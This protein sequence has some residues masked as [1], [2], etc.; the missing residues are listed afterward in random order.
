MHSIVIRRLLFKP[1]EARRA[2]EDNSKSDSKAAAREEKGRGGQAGKMLLKLTTWGMHEVAWR[3]RERGGKFLSSLSI[4][5][6]NFPT[7]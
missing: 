7:P 3:S 2:R 1:D 4:S 6:S 5:A